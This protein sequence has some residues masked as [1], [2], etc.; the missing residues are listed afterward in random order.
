M[1]KFSGLL[2]GAVALLVLVVMVAAPALIDWNAYKPEIAERLGRDLG[3]RVEIAGDLS[4]SLLP[5]PSISAEDIRLGEGA[6]RG[7]V[8]L[9]SIDRLR[10]RLKPLALLGGRLIV[11]EMV[12]VAPVV[13]VQT[14]EPA[15]VPGNEEATAAADPARAAGRAEFVV[16]RLVVQD[17]RMRL[18]DGR[19]TV[20][21]LERL[22]GAWEAQDDGGPVRAK[23]SFVWNEV[24]VA[25][26]ASA[27]NPFAWPTAVSAALRTPDAEAR[28]SGQLSRPGDEWNLRGKVAV[29]GKDFQRAL[30]PAGIQ[31]PPGAGGAF[32]LEG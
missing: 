14:S 32:A 9:A 8:G 16:R 25:F 27:G 31:V 4:L 22:D 18:R 7:P 17:G 19:E 24:P 15:A 21:E 5:R 26:E 13:V 6:Y 28:I 30:A 20:A 1:N 3:R 11:E 2:A 12:L 10:L 29:T 23:G